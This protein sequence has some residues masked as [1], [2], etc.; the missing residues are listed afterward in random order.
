MSTSILLEA[1]RSFIMGTTHDG[2]AID[3]DSASIVTALND[4]ESILID[5]LSQNITVEIFVASA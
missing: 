5:S 2:I 1:G 3:D 4:L